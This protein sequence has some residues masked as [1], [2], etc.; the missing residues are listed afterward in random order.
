LT[1]PSESSDDPCDMPKTD[2]HPVGLFWLFA[3]FAATAKWVT[4]SH[5]VRMK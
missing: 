3:E 5:S 4:H 2:R 1:S